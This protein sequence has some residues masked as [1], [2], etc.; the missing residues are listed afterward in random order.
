MFSSVSDIEGGPEDSPSSTE[1]R[2]ALRRLYHSRICSTHGFIPKRLFL[3]FQTC[4]K[5]FSLIWN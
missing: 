4:P 2:P 1:H 5:S 3:S